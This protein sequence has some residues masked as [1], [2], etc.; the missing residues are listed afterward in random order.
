MKV[1]DVK[2]IKILKKPNEVVEEERKQKKPNE[3]VMEEENEEEGK[4]K[5]RRFSRVL[6]LP[7]NNVRTI[8]CM[9]SVLAI[10]LFNLILSGA[11]FLVWWIYVQPNGMNIQRE[12]TIV[13]LIGSILYLLTF[14]YAFRNA[15]KMTDT[16]LFQASSKKKEQTSVVH[17][18]NKSGNN[19]FLDMMKYDA[20]IDF[21]TNYF[22]M[23]GKYY[24]LKLNISEVMEHLNQFNNIFSIYNCSLSVGYAWTIYIVLAIESL[25]NAYVLFR[26]K[27]NGTT[28]DHQAM[29]D[30]FVDFF[31]TSFP[32]YALF[33]GMQIPIP[34]WTVLQV[35]FLPALGMYVKLKALQRQL[36]LEKL[37]VIRYNAE[38][39]MSRRES[40][41]RMSLFGARHED[42][43]IED[44]ISYFSRF[45]QLIFFTINFL[46]GTF[47]VVLLVT[48]IV[49]VQTGDNECIAK[50]TS[51]IWEHC[52]AKIPY[53]GQ[54]FKPS[55]NC[56][57]IQTWWLNT[58]NFTT[59]PYAEHGIMNEM[60]GLTYISM[61]NGPLVK[62]PENFCEIHPQ[63][64]SIYL[65][66]NSLGSF[67]IE[68]CQS[69]VFLVLNLNRLKEL[70]NFHN[71]KDTIRGV[72]VG[73]N[74]ISKIP[75]WVKD[76]HPLAAFDV[77][78]NN[79]TEIDGLT[80]S[81]LKQ[82][83]DLE[84]SSNHLI[85][86]LPK[87]IY[88]SNILQSLRIVDLPHLK[89]LPDLSEGL[90]L[91][92]ELDI[93][94]TSISSLPEYFFKIKSLKYV[95]LEGTPLCNNGWLDTVPKDSSF[96]IAISQPDMG[97]AKQCSIL[98]NSFI[99]SLPYCRREKCGNAA[100]K[101]HDGKCTLDKKED[102]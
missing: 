34:V 19:V 13:F 51:N 25:H 52:I 43:V 7:S 16:V 63:M 24:L 49:Q 33:Y 76:G 60:T 27:I 22:Y 87:G 64:T 35:V 72:Y 12:G 42:V 46:F 67:N 73:G 61:S 48:Q 32:L 86:T 40:R 39:V 28:R 70:P 80:F 84:F 54:P 8:M 55:C 92:E 89:S 31:C 41:R 29:V 36:I 65:A 21:Y 77:S 2:D 26:G 15:R 37:R 45:R 23:E 18:K 5:K 83:Q 44:Q 91:L 62:L 47:L 93:R 96:G 6:E 57:K 81:S 59:L 97:C 85:S 58:H 88:S 10:Q 90:P 66:N 102:V 69:I 56:L 98:C 68:K 82:I 95:Y 101:D 3:V 50:D 20:I 38:S 11:F 71:S 53:C 4:Q 9:P 100:C 79:I 74:K 17:V 1:V 94:N 75:S 14:L 78:Q 99:R 30:L